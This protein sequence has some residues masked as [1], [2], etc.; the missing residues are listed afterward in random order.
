M[1][2]SYPGS[3]THTQTRQVRIKT[4]L[5]FYKQWQFTHVYIEEKTAFKEKM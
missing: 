5:Q 2:L 4:N 1:S 3:Y